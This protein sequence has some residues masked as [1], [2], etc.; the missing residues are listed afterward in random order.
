MIGAGIIVVLALLVWLFWRH[1]ALYSN[2]SM[3]DYASNRWTKLWSGDL[4]E[5]ESRRLAGTGAINCGRAPAE[6][7]ERVNDCMLKA[8]QQKGRAFWGRYAMPAIDANVETAVVGS[9]DGHTYE[10]TFK[11]GPHVPP[12]S[13]FSRSE[14]PQPR[15]LTLTDPKDWD[16]GRLT[17]QKQTA[18]EH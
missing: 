4:L 8:A 12:E 18:Y 10:I 15:N 6:A 3:L 17:C 14:C 9:V 2:R 16:Q 5:R 1:E 13:R 7:A 11:E